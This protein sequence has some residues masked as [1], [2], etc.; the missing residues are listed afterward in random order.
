MQTFFFLHKTKAFEILFSEPWHLNDC[1]LKP[2]CAHRKHPSGKSCD[3]YRMLWKQSL[4]WPADLTFHQTHW[5]PVCLVTLTQT[6]KRRQV[7]ARGAAL[8]YQPEPPLWLM[9][10]PA[11]AGVLGGP[12]IN[13]TDS[14]TVLAQGPLR[15]VLVVVCSRPG[16][17]CH[18]DNMRLKMFRSS[19]ILPF[20]PTTDLYLRDDK[21]V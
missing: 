19:L 12:F 21:Q 2:C 7:R 6:W 16:V 3:L 10:A 20:K 18:S 9:R 8:G 13:Q 17:K 5:S 14:Y 1:P 4:E 11:D 15:W